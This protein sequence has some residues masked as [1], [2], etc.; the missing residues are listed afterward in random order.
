VEYGDFLSTHGLLLTLLFAAGLYFFVGKERFP[1]AYRVSFFLILGGLELVAYLRARRR[2]LG[3][4][5][6]QKPTSAPSDWSAASERLVRD[7]VCGVFLSALAALPL[8][9]EGETVYFCSVR[10]RE[11][12]LKRAEG[13]TADT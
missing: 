4:S 6:S 7:P 2:L 12:Y 11:E 8:Q 1:A 13:G 5:T 10:C 9:H 3:S